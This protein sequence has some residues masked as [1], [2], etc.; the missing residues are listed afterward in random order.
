MWTEELDPLEVLKDLLNDNWVDHEE[1]PKPREILVQ[2]EVDNTT[3]RFD[4]T[5]GDVIV[6]K[7]EGM[8][9]IK[10]RGNFQY[11]D[12]AFPIMIEFYTKESRSRLRNLGKMIRAICSANKH[13]FDGYQLIRLREYTEMVEEN[14]NIWKGIQKVQVE[15]A[16]VC[17]EEP[18]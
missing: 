17:Q 1:T 10:Q 6:I 14:L 16:A 11:F 8:E 7:M 13:D 4:L 18:I 3:A 9:Q 5:L 12:R 2:N 15:S